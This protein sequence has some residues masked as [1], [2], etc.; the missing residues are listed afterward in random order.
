MSQLKQFGLRFNDG[1]WSNAEELKNKVKRL[2]ET[3]VTYR[4]LV[5]INAMIKQNKLVVIYLKM[6]FKDA[7]LDLYLTG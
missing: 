1:I 7:F 5:Y 2:N 4:C 6:Y 3:A